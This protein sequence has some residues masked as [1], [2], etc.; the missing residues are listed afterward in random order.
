MPSFFTEL[1]RRK[2]FQVAVVYVVIGWLLIQVADASFEHLNLPDWTITLVIVLVVLG[3]PLALVLGWAHDITPEGIKVTPAAST[4]DAPPAFVPPESSIA[5]LAFS[6]MS[7]EGDQD[8]FCDGI[9][10]EIINSLAQVEDVHVTSRTSSFQYKGAAADVRTIG[11]ELGVACVLEGSVRKAGDQLRVTVQLIAVASDYH[12]WSERYD[13]PMKDIFEIQD[14]IAFKVV[15]ALKVKLTPT[16]RQAIEKA[17]TESV[18]AYDYY[19]RGRKFARQFSKQD[20]AFALE[21]FGKAIEA[22]PTFALAYAGLAYTY[23]FL[24]MY[25]DPDRKNLDQACEASGK[26]LV[27]AP[28]L[29]EGHAARAL[30]LSQRG[31]REEARKEFELSLDLDPE[32]F[33]AFHFYGRHCFGIG[34]Y[35]RGRQLLEKACALEPDNYHPLSDLCMV[36]DRLGEHGKSVEAKNKLN[37]LISRHLDIHPDDIRARYIGACTLVEIGEAAKALSWAD[38][39]MDTNPRDP[40]TLYN[41]ACVYSVSGN[42]GQALDVLT[43]AVIAGFSDVNWIKSDPQLDKIRDE[44]QFQSLLNGLGK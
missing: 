29:A 5:V 27:L 33:E 3:L 13:R 19:L 26:A 9:A 1:K 11:N 4:E 41:L 23:T 30:A 37:T 10:E 34:D 17:P 15:E 44:P 42:T 31:N 43:K 21:M 39:I 35:Q 16:A 40:A 6:D 22:D 7:P 12:L 36:Y 18:T 2:V 38:Q 8:Y 24:Y 32:S 14:D 28:N 25:S 20:Y